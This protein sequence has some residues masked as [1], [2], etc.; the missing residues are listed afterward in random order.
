MTDPWDWFI[1]LYI[2]YKTSTIHVFEYI[3]QVH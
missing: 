2:Y 3:I 1:Y